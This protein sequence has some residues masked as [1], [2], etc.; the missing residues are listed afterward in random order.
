MTTAT[1]QDLPPSFQTIDP[2]VV[3]TREDWNKKYDQEQK[4]NQQPGRF[5]KLSDEPSLFP[6]YNEQQ[7]DAVQLANTRLTE[8]VKLKREMEDLKQRVRDVYDVMDAEGFTAEFIRA[9]K[10]FV[11][12]TMDG[13]LGVQEQINV[14]KRNLNRVQNLAGVLK[15]E[16]KRRARSEELSKESTASNVIPIRPGID[17]E[18]QGTLSWDM[19]GKLQPGTDKALILAIRE[20]M[21]KKAAIEQVVS[22]TGREKLEIEAL[23]TNLEARQEAPRIWREG[24]NWLTELPEDGQ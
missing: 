3:F 11:E 15:W 6:A 2:S 7:R 8:V 12:M 13:I 22:M 20:G 1:A 5:A 4:E 14:E 19:P 16:D 10:Q 21:G 18:G 23:W 9:G 24:R 17:L